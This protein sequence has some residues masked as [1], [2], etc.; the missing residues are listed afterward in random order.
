MLEHRREPR[1][2]CHE[3]A[4][5]Q[6]FNPASPE[7]LEIRV[8][9]TSEGGLAIYS[10]IFLPRGAEVRV[11]RGD[12]FVYGTIRYCVPSGS[13]FRAGVEITNA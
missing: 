5:L 1:H 10:P 2:L 13:G 6:V 11:R 8:I 9:D 7:R 4:F 3:A 12:N